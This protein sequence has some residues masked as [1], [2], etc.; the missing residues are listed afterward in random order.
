[1]LLHGCVATDQF[2]KPLVDSL[3]TVFQSSSEVDPL[4][5]ILVPTI[6][7]HTQESIKSWQQISINFASYLKA[8]PSFLFASYISLCPLP[9]LF[10]AGLASP[11]TELCSVCLLGTFPG[12]WR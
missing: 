9:T 2:S 3:I 11:K 6:N 4:T 10:S 1:M 7:S 5:F 8:P 12:S